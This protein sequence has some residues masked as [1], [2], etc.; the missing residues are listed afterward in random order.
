VFQAGL[1]SLCAIVPVLVFAL[2]M[3]KRL[4]LTDGTLVAGILCG[5]LFAMEF[6]MVFNALDLTSVARVSVLF[7][8][9]PVWFTVAAHFLLP[10]ESLTTQRFIGLILA[11]AG[12]AVAMTSREGGSADIAGDL[13]AI[14]ASLCWTAIALMVRGSRLKRASPE[15]QLLYQLVVSAMI[16]L[17]LSLLFGDL[18]RE[19]TVGLMWVFLFQVVGVIAIGFLL[20]FWL[21]SIYPAASTASLVFWRRCL[22]CCLGG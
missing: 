17:P 13:L 22:G 8:T 12:V 16:L 14:G 7:Y 1:R 20:W 11:V 9:M 4:S 6:I 5:V 3:K 10:N 19:M 21:L 18:I 2:L 15:M